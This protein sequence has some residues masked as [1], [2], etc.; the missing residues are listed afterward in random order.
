M[1]GLMPWIQWWLQ[2]WGDKVAG[3]WKLGTTITY[4]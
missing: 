3:V 4:M 2:W 1:D